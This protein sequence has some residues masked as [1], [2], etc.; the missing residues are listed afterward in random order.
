[1]LLAFVTEIGHKAE[2]IPE[3]AEKPRFESSYIREK[4]LC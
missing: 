3:G 2:D 4:W 1:M